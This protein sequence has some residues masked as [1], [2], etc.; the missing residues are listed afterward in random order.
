[1]RRII[2]ISGREKIAIFRRLFA[3]LSQ[4]IA[5]KKT[6]P[7]AIEDWRQNRRVKIYLVFVIK[8]R[9]GMDSTRIHFDQ[10]KSLVIRQSQAKNNDKKLGK[11]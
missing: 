8:K 9:N 3:Q 11:S 7:R 1:M 6:L 5:T 2:V 4:Q 10:V